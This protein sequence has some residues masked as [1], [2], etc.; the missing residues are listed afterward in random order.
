MKAELAALI[1]II[2]MWVVVISFVYWLLSVL[3]LV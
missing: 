2:I 1:I 3:G